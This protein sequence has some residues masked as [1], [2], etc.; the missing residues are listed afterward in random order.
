VGEGPGAGNTPRPRGFEKILSTLKDH[1]YPQVVILELVN[2]CNLRCVM[3][4]QSKLTRPIGKMD[5]ALITKI[6]DDLAANSPESTDVWLAIM[7]EVTVLGEEGLEHIEFVVR[8]CK[9]RVNFNTNLVP[10]D[11]RYCERLVDAGLSKIVVGVDAA[12]KETYEKV[13]VNGNFDRLTRNIEHILA[14]KEGRK[15]EKPELVLQ[16][17]VQRENAH[18]ADLFRKHWAG[19]NVVLKVR[20]RLGWGTGVEA[21]DLVIAGNRRDYPCPW[22]NRTMS[23]HVTGQVAQCDA[24]WDGRYYYGDLH[25]Q[26]I[27]EVWNG[28]LRELRQRHA[29]NDFEFEPCRTCNDWQCG[30]S[31]IVDAAERRT[32]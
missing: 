24:A 4:P 6:A 12:T 26:T 18:E 25:F 31:E 23:I 8:R 2:R 1:P 16:F 30:L 11:E 13:R 29:R 22:L 21:P 17:I 9:R 5:R 7:G 32:T 14:Y 27:S 10:P 20:P 15:L 28:K 19:R 3:C